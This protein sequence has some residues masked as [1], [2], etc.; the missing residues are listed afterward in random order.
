MTDWTPLAPGSSEDPAERAAREAQHQLLIDLLGA[1]AD[2]ELPPETTSQLDAHPAGAPRAHRFG[3]RGDARSG[4]GSGAA[5]V[6]G[7]PAHP[8][9]DR[10]RRRPARGG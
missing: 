4:T 1:Y 3:N 7:R 2:G 5:A 8:V 6:A 10:R 9:G